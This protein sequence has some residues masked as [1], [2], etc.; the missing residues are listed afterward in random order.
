M[1]SAWIFDDKDAAVSNSNI[2]VHA[3]ETHVWN[4]RWIFNL[5][6]SLLVP[7]VIIFNVRD[8]AVHDQVFATARISVAELKTKTEA[9]LCDFCLPFRDPNDEAKVLLTVHIAWTWVKNYVIPVD[10]IGSSQEHDSI[11][12]VSVCP[13]QLESDNTLASPTLASQITFA[14]CSL[15]RLSLHSVMKME[16]VIAL[17]KQQRQNEVFQ[18]QLQL[19]VCGDLKK[20]NADIPITCVKLVSDHCPNE[21]CAVFDCKSPNLQIPMQ[22]E[23]ATTLHSQ[24][25]Q[26]ELHQVYVTIKSSSSKVWWLVSEFAIGFALL[27]A[28]TTPCGWKYPILDNDDSYA[29]QLCTVMSCGAVTDAK[30]SNVLAHDPNPCDAIIQLLCLRRLVPQSDVVYTLLARLWTT[31]SGPQH[32]EV[33]S[34]LMWMDEDS[35]GPICHLPVFDTESEIIHVDIYKVHTSCR[36]EYVGSGMFQCR[37]TTKCCESNSIESQVSRIIVVNLAPKGKQSAQI[38]KAR[39]CVT[40]KKNNN[41]PDP[42]PDSTLFSSSFRN[43]STAFKC[44]E[45]RS[46]LFVNVEKLQLYAEIYQN[47]EAV[48]VEFSLATKQRWTATTSWVTTLHSGIVKFDEKCWTQI[49]WSSKDRCIPMLQLRIKAHQQYTPNMKRLG[50]G[51]SIKAQ[52]KKNVDNSVCDSS[53]AVVLGTYLLDLS[54][55]FSQPRVWTRLKIPVSSGTKESIMQ[56]EVAT[57]ITMGVLVSD[58]E[59][60]IENHREEAPRASIVNGIAGSGDIC[61]HLQQATGTFLQ[62][63]SAYFVRLSLYNEQTATR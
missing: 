27:S 32:S 62:S 24:Q 19:L 17:S 45:G 57:L 40:I 21:R 44:C 14:L 13:S 41:V 16:K 3:E 15:C 7:A 6:S 49:F 25:Q 37:A 33:L 60:Q 29:G 30:L 53:T 4:H 26:D 2:G 20:L 34:G 28:W 39:F 5:S 36:K 31:S 18:V 48:Q 1:I 23:W 58:T 22:P 8:S 59:N 63:E 10:R 38:A 43:T 12:D 46:W 47:Y 50:N 52:R 9:G 54:A 55:F 35:Q 11:R 56:Q 51:V 42:Q 61:V